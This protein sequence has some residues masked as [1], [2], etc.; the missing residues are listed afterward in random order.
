MRI[1]RGVVIVLL[2]SLFACNTES[3]ADPL[4]A[5]PLIGKWEIAANSHNQM[6]ECCEF[7]EFSLDENR[8]D[9]VGSFLSYNK[10]FHKSGSFEY[11]EYDKTILL[12]FE[13]DQYELNEMQIQ[14]TILILKT[15]TV[16]ND[17]LTRTYRKID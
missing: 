6:I 7:L 16:D 17:T 13:E 12:K 1:L 2:G 8:E 5:N 3:E 4:M 11:F 14:A 15:M 10:E 9:F